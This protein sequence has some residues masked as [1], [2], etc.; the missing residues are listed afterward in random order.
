MFA[1]RPIIGLI[2]GV[3]A[4][5]SHVA[6]LFEAAGCCRIASDEM[7]RAAYTHPDVKREVVGRFGTE[8]LDEGG[9]VDRKK[10]ADIVFHEPAQRQWLEG[11]LHPVANRARVE[12]MEQAARDDRVI[13]YV[14]DSPLLL[15]AGLDELCDAVV[16]VDAP[17]EDRLRRVAERGWDAAE[18]AR[19]ESAQMPLDKKRQRA[20][21]VLGNSDTSPATAQDVSRLLNQILGCCAGEAGCCGGVCSPSPAGPCGCA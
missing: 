3:G 14:W 4:G 11:L 1:G 5:K 20:D 12:L 18:L 8:V 2:G 17:L 7:V 13:A 16:Y 15:E 9:R 6:R 19:R 10:V 21:H